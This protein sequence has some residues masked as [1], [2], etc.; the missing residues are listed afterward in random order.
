MWQVEEFGTSHEG[1]PGVL[2]ADGSEPKPVIFDTGSGP[3]VHE[4]SDWWIYNGTLRAPRATDLRGSCSCG[5]RG[6]ERYPVD[7]ES[8]DSRRPYLFDTQGPE[9][10]WQRHMEEVGARSTPLPAGLVALLDQVGEQLDALV[11]DA[12]L[13]ALKAVAALERITR[14]AGEM[15]AH[16]VEADAV[17]DETLAAALGLTEKDARSR[18]FH[19][20][21][22]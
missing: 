17:S 22:R 20:A 11:T 9:S 6:G 4:S 2:L 13:A 8:V 16:Y 1:R 18:L 14:D 12:P 3:T 7:W 21:H 10:D 15:A 5:W 19:Y